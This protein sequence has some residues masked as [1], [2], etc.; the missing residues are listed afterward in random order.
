MAVRGRTGIFPHQIDQTT[1][2]NA[3]VDYEHK[4]V[5]AGDAFYVTRV[6]ELDNGE[7][8]SLRFQTPATAK[9]SHI[10][11]SVE[12]QARMTIVV[13]ETITDAL[14]PAGVLNR[15]RNYADALA[16]IVYDPQAAAAANGTIIYTWSS[17]GAAASP[18]RGGSPGAL[19]AS[20]EIVLKANE[21]YEWRITSLVNNNTISAYF[22]WYEHTNI[23]N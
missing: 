19:R 11:W 16:T 1:D 7:L 12:S 14:D 18:S 13:R 2:C 15:N 22:T 8:M 9:W 20:G 17:G 4:E 5:H 6:L 10:V 21:K 3:M 23:E